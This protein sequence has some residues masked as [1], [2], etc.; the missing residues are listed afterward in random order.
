MKV[1]NYLGQVESPRESKTL[2]NLR[3]KLLRG[4]LSHNLRM[5]SQSIP[6]V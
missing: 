3:S 1:I 4:L 2:L 5:F 6:E